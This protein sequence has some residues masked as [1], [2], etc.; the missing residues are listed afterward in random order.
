MN[1]ITETKLLLM[2]QTGKSADLVKAALERVKN[3]FAAVNIA[4]DEENVRVFD[5]NPTVADNPPAEALLVGDR[6]P[7]MDFTVLMTTMRQLGFK[8]PSSRGFRPYY[9]GV[10]EES[11]EGQYIDRNQV[12]VNV[13]TKPN[14]FDADRLQV[15]IRHGGY[16]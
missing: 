8:K 16:Y 12:S 2:E 1:E 11:Q 4:F 6:P 7:A 3:A 5:E 9:G 15:T 10:T 14:A 13:W